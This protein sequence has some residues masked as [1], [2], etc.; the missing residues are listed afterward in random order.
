MLL[1]KMKPIGKVEITVM[2]PMITTSQELWLTIGG[3]IVKNSTTKSAV[4]TTFK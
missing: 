2:K 4:N 1:P 3:T